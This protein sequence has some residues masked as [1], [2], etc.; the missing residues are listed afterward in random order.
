MLP[1]GAWFVDDHSTEPRSVLDCE[2]ATPHCALR[3]LVTHLPATQGLRE[4]DRVSRQVGALLGLLDE[5]P[6]ILAG[7][8]N[9]ELDRIDL[10]PL[11]G[12]L[13]TLPHPPTFPA[14]PFRDALIDLDGAPCYAIDHL[15]VSRGVHL[16]ALRVLE[17]SVTDHLPLLAELQP[18]PSSYRPMRRA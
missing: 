11:Q 15:L 12:R 3:V 5:R 6:T 8:L 2:V 16:R 9:G 17:Q 4:S 14:R 18:A 13:H 1:G 7:D 10:A